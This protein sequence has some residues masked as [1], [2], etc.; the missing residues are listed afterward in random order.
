MKKIIALL[1]ALVMCFSLAACS[2]LDELGE[3]STESQKTENTETTKTTESGNGS[4]DLDVEGHSDADND[5]TCDDC[6]ISVVTTFDFYAINDLH[7]KLVTS[8]NTVGVEGLSTYMKQSAALDDNPIFLSSGDMWQGGAYSNLTRGQIITEWMNSM[9]FSSMTL[10]NHEFDWGEEAIEENAELAK[11]PLLAINVYDRST[12]QQAEYCES[13]VLVECRGLQVGIIGAIGDC[14]SSISSDKVE[15]VYF[16]TGSALTELVK[17]E[18]EKLRAMGAELIV[19]SLHDGGTGSVGSYY[20][21]ALSN[22]YVDIVF[23]GHSHYSYVVRD[24]YGIYHMQNSG[25]N[26]GISHAEIEYNFANGTYSVTEA[27]HVPA[28]EYSALEKDALIDTLLEKYKD[29]VGKAEEILGTN[30]AV[31]DADVLREL[32]AELYFKAGEERW[33]DEYDIVLGG[34]YMSARSPGYLHAGEVTYGDLQAI[35]PFDNELVLC[36][37]KGRDLISQFLQTT[38]TNYFIFCGDYGDSIKNN[39][40]SN[41]TYYLITDT[42]SSGYAPNRLTEIARYDAN[43]FARDLLADYIKAGGFDTGTG[44]LTSIPDIISIG[45]ALPAGGVSDSTYCVRGEVISVYNTTYGNMII[46]DE[47]GNT[48]TVYGVSD[49]SGTRYDRM[50]NAPRV[51]DVV[52]VS[53]PIKHYVSNGGEVIIELFQS[54]LVDMV[55][56]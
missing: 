48:L 39:I 30:T 8:G 31:R 17:A 49:A 15:D 56:P 18:S 40:D 52:T 26:G 55:K 37:I 5:K 23:E 21:M 36:S 20:D 41:A 53:A 32:I 2:M 29:Q 10:G 4:S 3:K 54:Y 43:V 13:S 11:F 24:S 22:G 50:E 6:G 47:Q 1:L 33:G 42:Y 16:K 19:F 28:R 9:N 34:G 25:D 14:Y 27:R 44:A 7:G 35:F 45:M 38:N 46:K 12:N 51:G